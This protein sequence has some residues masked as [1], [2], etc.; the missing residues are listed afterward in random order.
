MT[1]PSLE[2]SPVAELP[3]E[4][5]LIPGATR[6]TLAADCGFSGS[7]Q[8]FL[9]HAPVHT[10]PHPRDRAAWL[11]SRR[12]FIGASEIAAVVGANPYAGPLEVWSA[13]VRPRPEPVFM[14]RILEGG[15]RVVKPNHE[16]GQVAEWPLLEDFMQRHR[17]TLTQP[18]TMRH[19]ERLHLAATPD[20]DVKGGPLVQV[21]KVGH[22]VDWV[23]DW[24]SGPPIYT[25]MQVQAEMFVWGRDRCII[26]VDIGELRE[27]E[28]RFDASLIGPAVEIVTAFWR[29]VEQAAVPTDFD[30]R[31]TQSDTLKWLWPE[32]TVLGLAQAEE[33]VIRVAQA[34]SSARSMEKAGS[35]D[36][37]ALGVQLKAMI[38]E[39]E[40]MYWGMSE[41]KN[42]GKITWTNDKPKVRHK[43]L[44]LALLEKFVGDEAERAKWVQRF[45]ETV[46]TRVLRVTVKGG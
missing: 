26:L 23:G 3:N 38:G 35:D 20:G 36:K 44:A 30:L 12:T 32:A 29:Y 22:R 7:W 25:L 46:G 13:K 14:P 21:K 1:L 42:L 2:S 43:D 45:T 24:D 9:A 34:Y 18:A 15:G 28:V 31:A 19:P 37:D 10:L 17:C 27:Y 39:R 6:C 33:E 4:G 5:L 16:V 8:A 41:K 11:D 40:G